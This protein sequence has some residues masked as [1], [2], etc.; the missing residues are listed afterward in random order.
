MRVTS[1]IKKLGINIVKKYH[2]TN[3]STVIIAVS[4][5]VDSMVLLN[6]INAVDISQR[7]KIIIAHVNHCLRTQSD[8][9]EKYLIEWSE[10]FKIQIEISHWDKVQHPKHGIEEAA[11]NYRFKFFEKLMIRYTVDFILTAHTSDDQSETFLMNVIRGGT[12]EQLKSIEDR[13]NFEGLKLIRPMLNFSKNEVIKLAKDNNVKWFEDN[14]NTSEVYFRNRIRR[15]VLPIMKEENPKVL[16]HIRHYAEQIQDAT[17]ILN[18]VID[19][20]IKI[21]KNKE[22]YDLL[23]FNHYDLKYRRLILRSIINKYDPSIKLGFVKL[24]LVIKFLFNNK[25]ANAQF[26]LGNNSILYKFYDKFKLGSIISFPQSQG[27]NG[28]K[29]YA[30]K[31]QLKNYQEV[32]LR[33]PIY[34]DHQTIIV[35]DYLDS[36]NLSCKS[37]TGSLHYDCKAFDKFVFSDNQVTFPLKLCTSDGGDILRLKDGGTKKVRREMIDQKIPKFQRNQQMIIKDSN[38]QTIWFPG[39]KKSYL[40]INLDENKMQYVLYKIKV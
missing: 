3:H 16:D 40:E 11:R 23:N 26:F 18:D 6:A 5:G 31:E 1:D 13:K 14:S 38:N 25:D 7:P 24:D 12:L 20:E 36:L 2:I 30:L 9:E 22:E 4:G 27:N 29:S 21:L 37:G 39:L 17:S 28:V 8:L 10:K 32:I 19:K 35:L 33:K 34:L 15:K